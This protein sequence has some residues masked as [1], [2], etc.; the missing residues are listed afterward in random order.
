MCD[1]VCFQMFSRSR[2][3]DDAYG[4]DERRCERVTDGEHM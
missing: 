1:V 2:E 4:W 3:L